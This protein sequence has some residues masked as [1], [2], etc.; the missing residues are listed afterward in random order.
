[1]DGSDL[2]GIAVSLVWVKV[3]ETGLELRVAGLVCRGDLGLVGERGGYADCDVDSDDATPS[4]HDDSDAV[5][6]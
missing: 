4:R 6:G 3:V 5:R 1:M 2:S